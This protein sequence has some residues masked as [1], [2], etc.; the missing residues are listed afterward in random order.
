MQHTHR[1]QND[2]DDA[3]RNVIST[4]SGMPMSSAMHSGQERQADVGQRLFGQFIRMFN[5]EFEKFLHGRYGLRYGLMLEQLPECG[6]DRGRLNGYKPLI[7]L[8]NDGFGA[9]KVHS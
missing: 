5:N 1:S 9:G 4:P 2:A 7:G 6:P 3:G 8:E